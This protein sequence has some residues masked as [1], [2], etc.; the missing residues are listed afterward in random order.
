MFDFQPHLEGSLVIMRPYRERDWPALLA[1]AS[2][3][4]IWEQHPIYDKWREEVFRTSIDSAVAEKGGLV[5]IDKV[6]NKIIGFSCFAT[7]YVEFGEI[8]IGWTFLARNHWD[9]ACT[10]IFRSEG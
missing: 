1:V 10:L 9:G 7:R 6:G 3:P 8:E 2:D 4:L 5:A